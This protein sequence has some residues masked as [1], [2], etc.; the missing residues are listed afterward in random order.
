MRRGGFGVLDTG[1]DYRHMQHSENGAPRSTETQAPWI[2]ANAS[3]LTQSGH[4][5]D[6]TNLLGRC[7]D[8]SRGRRN[9]GRNT[10]AIPFG[11]SL[12][13][14]WRFAQCQIGPRRRDFSENPLASQLADGRAGALGGTRTPNL[15]IRREAPAV[16]PVRPRPSGLLRPALPSCQWPPVLPVCLPSVAHQ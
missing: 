3:G 12:K 6:G 13:V 1:P 9:A 10:I 5:I 8:F 7:L 11:S 4:Q 15:L 2:P 14:H 16:W